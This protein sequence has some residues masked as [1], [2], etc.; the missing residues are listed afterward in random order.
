MLLIVRPHFR[1]ID[2]SIRWK[3]DSVHQLREGGFSGS[4][5]SQNRYKIA[6]LDIQRDAF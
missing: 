3:Q 1:N 5:M 4:V 2:G 6:F